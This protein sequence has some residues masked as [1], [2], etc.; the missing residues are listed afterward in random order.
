MH[1]S[2]T[3]LPPRPS[4]AHTAQNL[5]CEATV[6]YPFHP[7]NGKSV[8]II[9][10]HWLAD[11]RH[12]VSRKPNGGRYSI[13]AWMVSEKSG[14]IRIVSQPRLPVDCLLELSLIVERL[15]CL[16]SKGEVSPGGLQNESMADNRSVRTTAKSRTNVRTT[17]RLEKTSRGA[18]K[19]GHGRS[20]SQRRRGQGGRR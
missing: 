1:A 3:L 13:P 9:G 19:G 5:P 14:T 17:D 11:V 7:L 8:L 2:P 15:I 6:A 4:G 20:P 16:S 12:L 18:V 10:E